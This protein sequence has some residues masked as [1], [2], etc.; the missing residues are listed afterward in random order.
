[1]NEFIK[2]VA[3]RPESKK[4][5]CATQDDDIPIELLGCF[6]QDFFDMNTDMRNAK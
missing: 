3:Q 5:R 1:M 6:K 2:I 4:N